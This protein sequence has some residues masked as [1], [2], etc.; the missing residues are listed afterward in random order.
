MCIT[1]TS[2]DRNRQILTFIVDGY[3]NCCTMRFTTETAPR[4]QGHTC[5]YYILEMRCAE[6]EFYSTTVLFLTTV[7]FPT[8]VLL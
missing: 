5:I 2:N 3:T 6:T 7:V 8:T 1:S 4:Q